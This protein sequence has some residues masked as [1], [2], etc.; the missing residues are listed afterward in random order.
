MDRNR[1]PIPLVVLAGLGAWGVSLARAAGEGP[2][3][4]QLDFFESRVRPILATNCQSCHG[5]SKQKGGLRLDSREAV[6][7]GGQSGP[8]VAP[9]EPDR[10]LL[11]E[12]IGYDG[13]T[14]M[15]PKGPLKPREVQALTEWVKMGAPWPEAAGRS[16]PTSAASTTAPGPGKDP[17]SHWAFRPVKPPALPT[18]KDAA[19]PKGSIDLFVLAKLEGRGLRPVEPAD[20]RTLIRRVTFDLTGLP[21]APEEVDAFLGDEAP[22]AYERLVDRLLAS[23]RYGERWGRH[24]LD[25]ARYGEDQAHTFQ[26]KKYPFGYKFRDWV[27]RALNADMPY[28]RFVTEQV[29][30]DL[31][32]G[33][34]RE[35]RLAA[36]GF[37][38]LG[39]VYYGKAIAD[40]RDDRIDT[41]S[42]GFLGLTVACA[43]CHDHKFDPIPTTDY[44]ALAGV[45]AST[46]FKEYPAAPQE[47]I[48][49]YDEAQAAIADKTKE[50][51]RF[52]ALAGLRGY[53]AIPKD[54]VERSLSAESKAR[55]KSLRDDLAR[56]KKVAPPPYPVVHALAE[57]ENA[58]NLRVNVRG[59]P[60]N[61]GPEVP[62]RFLTA[63]SEGEPAPF[64]QGS[65]RL[66]LARAIA[67]EDNP[68]TA[69]VMVNRIWEHHFGR[70][71]VATPSNFG[72]LGE[73]PTHPDLLDYLAGRFVALG[74]SMK[75]IHREILLS[76]TYQLSSRIDPRNQA[77]DADNALLWRMNRRRL[78]VEAWRDAMLAASGELDPTIGGPSEELVAPGNRRRTF[79]AA[80]SRHNLDSLLRLFDFPDP[81]IT[82]D[83]RVVTSVPLQQLFVLNSEFMVRQAK[84]LAKRLTSDPAGS[85]AERIRR[86]FPLLYG[87]PASGEEVR[88]GVAFLGSTQEPGSASWKAGGQTES[89]SEGSRGLTAWEQ[90]AQA[91]LGAN[92]FMFV[93]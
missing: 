82:C 41:L 20:K 49:R 79:Y 25:V 81:N 56:L 10:S 61:L 73:P 43:R 93:D 27:V 84:A 21:P 72:A 52:T 71:L 11:I 24:W 76:A 65:G 35:G 36:L 59:N 18:V 50:I 68:L 67:S 87:R 62:R 1:F 38:A 85:D 29:A 55:L 47:E 45:F 51:D 40:E 92:E 5:A 31:I 17:K 70:G 60:E 22:N 90:Y 9:G 83:R 69:R 57:S 16:E 4:S 23:P 32:D 30:G 44:Y 89:G 12:A 33:P 46:Q 6:L 63:L 26:A 37:F 78:E 58:T 66:E 75:A 7:K 53:Y 48:R 39:P 86:A 2:D 74:W 42:R 77:V 54:Q 15:P 91:L 14:Q 19:W 8:A 13:E 80:V 34:D 28:D 64:R 3:R 88:W